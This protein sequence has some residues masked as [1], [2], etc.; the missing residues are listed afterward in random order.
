MK[1]P[2]IHRIVELRGSTRACGREYGQQMAEAITGFVLQDA[3]M[4][5]SLAACCAGV[6]PDEQRLAYARDCIEALRRWDKKV[7]EFAAG[8]A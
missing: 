4:G 5:S 8:M 6:A 2:S 7:A 3:S 1:L